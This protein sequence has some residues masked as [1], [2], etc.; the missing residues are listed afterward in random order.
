MVN[1]IKYNILKCKFRTFLSSLSEYVYPNGLDF[2]LS[3][4]VTVNGIKVYLTL[5]NY[6]HDVNELRINHNINMKLKE[7]SG[8]E[9]DD[10]DEYTITNMIC[11][12][13]SEKHNFNG[14]VYVTV[15]KNDKYIKELFNYDKKNK[16]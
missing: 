11:D 2:N 16:K 15:L 13:F 7:H 10:L 12:F 1:K 14:V 3:T 6:V 5:Y 8:V 9:I 4:N